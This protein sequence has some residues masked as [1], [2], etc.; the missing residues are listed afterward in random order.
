ME[1]SHLW[2]DGSYQIETGNACTSERCCSKTEQ[3]S[4]P[5]RPKIKFLNSERQAL[6]CVVEWLKLPVPSSAAPG[7]RESVGREH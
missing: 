5:G 7:Y 2:E 4:D 3:A 1:I 6:D